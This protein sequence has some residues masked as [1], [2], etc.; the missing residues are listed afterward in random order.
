[1]NKI[2]C[3]G[4]LLVAV[5]CGDAIP[6]NSSEHSDSP[7]TGAQALQS[8]PGVV[9]VAPA[10]PQADSAK[11]LP[12]APGDSTQKGCMNDLLPA[13]EQ[14]AARRSDEPRAD[15]SYRRSAAEEAARKAAEQPK[16]IV[17]QRV[18]LPP[19]DPKWIEL[20]Q[21]YLA[22]LEQL[23]ARH[24]YR[25]TVAFERERVALKDRILGD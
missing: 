6:G 23:R 5:G 25:E 14:L 7:Q 16:G 3:A 11:A 24:H 13:A 19:V 8:A 4:F 21:Q 1:M 10:G 15:P 9:A 2:I 22:E 12:V 20:Q 17:E 18:E